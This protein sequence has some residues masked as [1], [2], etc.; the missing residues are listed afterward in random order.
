VEAK[1]NASIADMLMFTA[2][3]TKPIANEHAMGYESEIE[4]DG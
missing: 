3:T 1:H 2:E 4:G